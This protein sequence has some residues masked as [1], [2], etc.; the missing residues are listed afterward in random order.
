MGPRLRSQN[1]H[2]LSRAPPARTGYEMI[3]GPLNSFAALLKQRTAH[4][5]S[6]RIQQMG[7]LVRQGVVLAPQPSLVRSKFR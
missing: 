7:Q 3:G 4:T 2:A 1:P 5:E 6:K